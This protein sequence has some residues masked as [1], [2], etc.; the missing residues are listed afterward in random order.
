M[1]VITRMSNQTTPLFVSEYGPCACS[2]IRRTART[3][4]LLYD[5]ALQP[6]GITVTQYAVLVNVA[7]AGEIGALRWRRNLAWIEPLSR[8]T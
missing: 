2:Q 4:S 7:R 8:A 1:S 3:L 6:A 5:K